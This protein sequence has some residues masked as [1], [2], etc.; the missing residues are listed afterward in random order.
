MT[1][2]PK[3]R[4]PTTNDKMKIAPTTRRRRSSKLQMPNPKEIP[5]TKF[6]ERFRT[7]ALG[8]FE[9]WDFFGTWSLGFGAY[10]VAVAAGAGAPKL[11]FTV[12]AFSAP[13]W[14]AKN[15][16]DANPNIPAIVFV[17]KRRT[18]VLKSCTA[19]LKLFL[20]TEIRFSVPSSCA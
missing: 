10:G 1:S 7:T 9:I 15:G 16:R 20:S 17:G 11:K 12:G 18:A 19:P 2:V 5:S 4:C 6:Q 8:G 13:C 14:A 3:P